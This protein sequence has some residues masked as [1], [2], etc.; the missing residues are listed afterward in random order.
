MEGKPNRKPHTLSAPLPQPH[1][2]S[3]TSTDT[4]S[5]KR[6]SPQRRVPL[7]TDTVSSLLKSTGALWTVPTIH[8]LVKSK[9]NCQL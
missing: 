8:D 5:F 4:V 6:G 7:N 1:T 3:L 2:L 9:I